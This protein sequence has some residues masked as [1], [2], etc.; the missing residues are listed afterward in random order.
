MGRWLILASGHD[1]SAHLAAQYFRR[2]GRATEVLVTERLEGAGVRWRH[3]VGVHGA[4]VEVALA[5]GRHLRSGDF[6]AVLNR[7]MLPPLTVM[8]RAAWEDSAYALSE[9]SAFALSWVNALAPNVVNPP[10]PRGLAGAWRSPLEWRS[11]AAAAGLEP[12][13]FKADTDALEAA[14]VFPDGPPNAL[15]IGECAFGAA[16][17]E[18][19]RAAAVRLA[20]LASTPIL[21]LWLTDGRLA[22]ATP[23]PD[24][25]M[26]G[27][28]GLAALEGLLA[29]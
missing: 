7:A 28:E 5:D 20:R 19:V 23:N 3:R 6:S 17:D 29:G 15:V 16:A 10:T 25:S 18:P 12:V 4:E 8:A 2:R 26:A 13:P 22:M 1:T 27:A 14:P 24:L 11:L 9:Q 21:G